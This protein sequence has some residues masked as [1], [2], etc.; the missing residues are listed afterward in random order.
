ME[1][2]KEKARSPLKE[3]ENLADETAEKIVELLGKTP[4]I[5]G[6]RKSHILSGMVGAAGVALFIVGVEKIFVDLPGITSLILGLSLMF[7][8]GFLFKNI[9]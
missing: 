7:L 1:T 8:A 3:P 9:Q 2:A 5:G 4:G 6:I